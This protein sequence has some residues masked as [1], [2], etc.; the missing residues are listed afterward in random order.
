MALANECFGG[1]LIHHGPGPGSGTV[2]P[3]QHLVLS[4]H[5]FPMRSTGALMLPA[6][7]CLGVCNSW[8][9]QHT[10][11]CGTSPLYPGPTLHNPVFQRGAGTPAGHGRCSTLKKAFIDL[12]EDGGAAPRAAEPDAAVID[13]EGVPT[14][15]GE[16]LPGPREQFCAFEF[17]PNL[18]L[19][20]RRM[21]P[22]S[23]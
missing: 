1:C 23:T 13:T 20:R 10:R 4:V 6:G 3:M 16:D 8:R 21:N 14:E 15:A 19:S 11:T 12:R 7:A 17:F 9:A 5:P 2:A 22:E 18:A